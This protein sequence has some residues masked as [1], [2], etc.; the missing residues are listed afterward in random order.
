MDS[1]TTPHIGAVQSLFALQE[2]LAW[3]KHTSIYEVRIKMAGKGWLAILKATRRTAWVVA[4][5]GGKDYHQTLSNLAKLLEDD[6]V[7]WRVD[8]YPPDWRRKIG[9]GS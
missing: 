2:E 6:D 8:D 1:R 4:F 9:N 3:A 7:I 5:V